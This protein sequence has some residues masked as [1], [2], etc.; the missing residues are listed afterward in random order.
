LSIRIAQNTASL[1]IGRIVNALLGGIASVLIVRALGSE[2]FGEFSSIYA[3][4][5]LFAWLSSVGIEPV[6]TREAARSRVQAGSIIATGAALSAVFA[7]LAT[8]LALSFARFGGFE[9]PQR[10]LLGLAAL[11]LL[12]FSPLRLTGCIFQV[13]LKQ[14]YPTAIG[15]T[16]QLFWLI[17]ILVLVQWKASLAGFVLGRFL[18]ACLELF[19]IVWAGAVRLKSPLRILRDKILI[20][21]R[22][23]AP[24]A[25]SA[26]LAGIY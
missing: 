14:L 8:V 4:I 24:I 7:L 11:E 15:V 13:D 16:R 5:S 17:A 9:R 12:L 21:F 10:V 2:Q 18:A 19:L 20:Y 22:A 3:Y 26:L 1:I 25:L 23:C 6:L